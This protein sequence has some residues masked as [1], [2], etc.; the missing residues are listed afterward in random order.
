MNRNNKTVFVSEIIVIGVI[1]LYRPKHKLS[2]VIPA[3]PTAAH[4]KLV[5]ESRAGTHS[6]QRGEINIMNRLLPLHVIIISPPG[7]V[8]PSLLQQSPGFTQI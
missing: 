2:Q 4:S 1:G 7:Y 8:L 6:E 5:C 3:E